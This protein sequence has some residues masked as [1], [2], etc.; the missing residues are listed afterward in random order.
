[1]FEVD[2]LGTPSSTQFPHPGYSFPIVWGRRVPLSV[3]RFGDFELDQ[4]LLGTMRAGTSAAFSVKRLTS[5]EMAVQATILRSPYLHLAACR[6]IPATR[7]SSSEP[8]LG[9]LL[10]LGGVAHTIIV[11]PLLRVQT[12]YQPQFED[13]LIHALLPVAGCFGGEVTLQ[14]SCFGCGCGDRIAAA[15]LFPPSRNKY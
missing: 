4:L 12:V 10:G 13:W 3:Y 2:D 6:W 11:T 14:R 5:A 9:V 7:S 15:A 1:M 8:P